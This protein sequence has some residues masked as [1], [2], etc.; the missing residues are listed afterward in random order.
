MGG[1]GGGGTTGRD[2]LVGVG[3]GECVFL[4]LERCCPN[5]TVNVVLV[6]GLEKGRRARWCLEVDGG[7]VAC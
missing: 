5:C 4:F 3:C 1:G 2:F 6:E 7:D